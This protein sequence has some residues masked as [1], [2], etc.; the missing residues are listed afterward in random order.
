VNYIV[1]YKEIKVKKKEKEVKKRKA[2]RK[3][4][5]KY[6]Y[7]DSTKCQDTKDGL[8]MTKK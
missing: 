5:T 6:I 3:K 1:E 8:E 4:W 7:I 2:E